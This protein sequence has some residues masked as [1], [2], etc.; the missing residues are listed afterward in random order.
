[1]V[2]DLR[3]SMYADFCILRENE[4]RKAPLKSANRDPETQCR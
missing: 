2:P 3:A 4:E 1:M